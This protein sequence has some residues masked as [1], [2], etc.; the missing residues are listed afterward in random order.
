MSKITL[1]GNSVTINDN[2][3]C[4][5]EIENET[6]VEIAFS[7]F[8]LISVNVIKYGDKPKVFWRIRC[9][10][11]VKYIDPDT[12]RISDD[13]TYVDELKKILDDIDRDIEQHPEKLIKPDPKKMAEIDDLV[14]GVDI[15]NINPTQKLLDDIRASIKSHYFNFSS[16]PHDSFY[17][18][19]TKALNDVNSVLDQFEDNI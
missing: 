7:V 16:G 17:D 11:V 1:I 10:C 13:N 14:R 6:R 3:I 19:Y 5:D 8:D 18:G 4:V 15:S 12:I 2:G 9:N